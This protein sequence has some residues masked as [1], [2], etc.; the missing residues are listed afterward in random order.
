MKLS[1][2]YAIL[3]IILN[4]TLLLCSYRYLCLCIVVY[5]LRLI[6]LCEGARF[7]FYLGALVGFAGPTRVLFE[8]IG[9][10]HR[11]KNNIEC[12][13]SHGREGFVRI[14]TATCYTSVPSMFGHIRRA[15]GESHLCNRSKP[16]LPSCLGHIIFSSNFC[17]YSCMC[18]G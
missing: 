5:M 6:V 2:T 17:I 18:I 11:S 12:C 7:M 4:R 3:D 14:V 1:S 15:F 10:V 13:V 9:V 8:D 16:V